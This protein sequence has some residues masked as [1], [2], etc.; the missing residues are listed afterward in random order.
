MT[1]RGVSASP[2]PPADRL[3]QRARTVE[4]ARRSRRAVRLGAI[5]ALPLLVGAAAWVLLGS[6][7]LDV[8][9][10]EVAG[11]ERVADRL[12]VLTADVPA[13]TPLARVDLGEVEERVEALAG[14]AD[15]TVLRGWPHTLRIVVSERVAAAVVAEPDGSWRLIDVEGRA[16]GAATAPPA[17]A[18]RVAGEPGRELDDGQ[19]RA[20]AAVAASL[21]GD[22]AGQVAAVDPKSAD[23]VRL[24]LIGGAEVRWGSP[25]EPAPKAAILRVLIQRPAEVYDVSTP[26]TPTT[27]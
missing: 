4:S 23:D 13:G 9:S 14:V 26:R 24:A 5:A 6:G 15:A 3:L 17:G 7:W 1:A 8:R 19:L 27:S 18:V 12:V 11:L 10:V 20:A 16:F 25:A 21:P 2:R 22:L